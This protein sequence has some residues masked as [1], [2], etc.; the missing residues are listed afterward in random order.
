MN[1]D[2]DGIILGTGHNAL[3]LQAY[4]A[5]CGL[6]VLSLD[7]AM[8]PGGGLATVENT[9]LHGFWHN[10][11]SFFHRA[12]TMMP[13]YGDLEL[14]RHGAVYLEPELNV[15]L[16]LHDGR[17]LE[18]WT[19][20][21]KTVDSFAEFSVRDAATLRRWVEEFRPIVEHI[22]L[23]EVQSPPLPPE[24]RSELLQR[25]A[26]GRRFLE[27]SARTPLQFV[28]EE[29][30]H[31]VVRAGLLFFNGMREIDLQAPG[32]GHSIA[33]ILAGRHKAQMCLGGSVRLAEA[34]AEDIREHGG[35]IRTGAQPTSILTRN[36]RAIGVALAHGRA[37][38]GRGLHRL[39]TQPTANVS[40]SA[41]RGGSP[42]A[43]ARASCRLPLQ[44]D[45]TLVLLE[46]GAPGAAAICGRCASAS[47]EPRIH[48]HPRPGADGPVPR[49]GHGA[50]AGRDPAPDHVGSVPDS[51]RP[52]PGTSGSAHGIHV[53]EAPLRITRRRPELGA[54]QEAH[55]RAMLALWSRF[56]PNL[57]E[58]GIVLDS[59]TR[60]PLDTER[61]LPNMCRGDLLVGSLSHGQVGYHR[62]FPGAGQY[63]TPVS[64][65]YLCGGSTHPGG[66][67]TGLCGYNAAAVLASDLGLDPWWNPPRVERDWPAR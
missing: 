18:W 66:N 25:S 20:F 19:D 52:Q 65:L 24:R 62:P 41:G 13:W 16:I 8:V 60:S 33:A 46:S 44:P 59:F 2:W 56:A 22:I 64:G 1:G 9:R 28:Q 36:G 6:R 67:I 26:L 45:R 43:D 27:V 7:R 31:E 29:F 38:R 54:E 58:D 47:I 14:R 23:P 40:G 48:G 30:E 4:L 10:T 57:A 53:G 61:S 3:V 39:R 51:V 35:E 17:S 63:R 49:D 42:A 12:V 11:H 15:A 34:L 5:R 21:D 50:P 55:G 32:F 37:H